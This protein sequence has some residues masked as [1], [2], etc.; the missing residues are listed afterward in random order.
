M[1]CATQFRVSTIIYCFVKYLLRFHDKLLSC[2]Y[3]HFLNQLFFKRNPPSYNIFFN[4]YFPK[5]ITL[6]TSASTQTNQNRNNLRK[7]K[8]SNTP[9]T[10]R[11]PRKPNPQR[12]TLPTR[13][14]ETQNP[15][16]PRRR[17][18]HPPPGRALRPHGQRRDTTT[19]GAGRTSGPTEEKSR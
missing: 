1:M 19:E 13:N 18:I 15:R 5:K 7:I 10:T 9:K 11:P 3:I 14:M 8:I 17:P 2:Q 12:N 16:T 6:S 4:N